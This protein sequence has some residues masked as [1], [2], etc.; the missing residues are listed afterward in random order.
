MDY[1]K[2]EILYSIT[3]RETGTIEAKL[4]EFMRL[5]TW[6]G[7]ALSSDPERRSSPL[8][9]FNLLIFI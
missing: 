2:I 4:I 7:G 1:N 3:G 8:L 6:Y 5:N 9:I